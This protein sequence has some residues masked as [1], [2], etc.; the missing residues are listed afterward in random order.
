MVNDRKDLEEQLG[1][2]ANLTGELVTYIT[3]SDDLKTTLATKSSNLNMVML[4]KFREYDEELPEYL[5][6]VL[7]EKEQVPEYVM[8]DVVNDSERIVI[9]IDEAHRS[10]GGKAGGM[11]DNLFAAFPH[12]TR[13]AFTGT[14][15]IAEHHTKEDMGTVWRLHRQIPFARCG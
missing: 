9:M 5:E 13:L 14:P 12:A 10:Q 2:T 4:H 6:D 7:G 3:S 11:G 1:E 15:L 8:M